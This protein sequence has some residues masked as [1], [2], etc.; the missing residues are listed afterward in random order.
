MLLVERI[1]LLSILVWQVST[2]HQTTRSKE[3]VQLFH[4]A[5]HTISYDNILQVDNTLAESTLK[6]MNTANG[7]VVPPN[8]VTNRFLHFTCDNIDINDSSLD[9]MNSFHATQVAA[10]QRGPSVDMGLP[11]LKPVKESTTRVPA[12]M[13][14]LIPADI[15]GGMVEPKST[16][17]TQK[18]WFVASDSDKPEVLKANACDLA[19]FFGRND[20]HE[21]IGWTNFNQKHSTVEP[22]VTSTGY[23]PI[24]QSPAHEF[25]TLNTVVLRCKHVANVLGQQYVV[26]TVD[27]TLYCKLMELKWA[28]SDY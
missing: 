24:V 8:L 13:E 10:W 11:N 15:R 6:S 14:E 25:D 26:L 23:M 9:G 2:L 18:D 7:A 1:G 4:N 17:S 5:G 21:R 3:L 16:S 27:E 22:E 28:K 12:I 20:S 19:F